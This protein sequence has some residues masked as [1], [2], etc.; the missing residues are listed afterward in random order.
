M[1]KE[2]KEYLEEVAEDYGVD[3][4][5]VMAVADILGPEEDHDGLISMIEDMMT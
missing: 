4:D 5:S 2:R 1:T 3:L